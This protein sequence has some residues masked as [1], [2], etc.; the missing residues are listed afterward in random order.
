MPKKRVSMRKIREVLRLT[1][2]L[3]LSVREVSKATGVGKTAVG[4]FVARAKV[5]GITWPVPPEI[6]DAELERRLFTPAE[7]HD[8][9]TR[10]VPD[11]A[12]VHEELKREGV[13]RFTLWEE[14]RAEVADGYGYA[15]FCQLYGEW[16]KR[17]SPTMR[18]THV[19]G[20][21][22]FVDWAGGKVP[23][24]NPVTGEVH[25]ASI[26]VAVLGA[27]SYSYSE[28]R[29]TETLPDWIGAHVNTLDFL[30][31]VMKAAVPD[32]LKAGITKPSRYEPG[33][34]RTYQ[35]LADH[36][37]FVV[38]PTRQQK[39]RDKA[40]VEN[41]VGIV[42]RYLLGRLRNRRFF[43]LAELNDATRECVAAINAKV[44][45]RLNKSRNELFA[46]L[47]RPALKE[48]PTERYSYAEWK[49]CTVAPD[50]H[51]EVELH[52]YSVPFR[53]LR[54]SIDA[55]YTDTT[56]E[57]FHKGER[58]A[59]H[60]RSK[61]PY[62]H[63]T[64]PEHMPSSH[65][66]YAE[67]TPARMLSQAGEIG[68]ATVALFEAIMRAKPH[69]E[70]GFRSCL[71]IISLLRSYGPERIEAAAK[72]GNDIGATSYGSIK[73]ILEKGLDRS[74]APSTAADTRPIQH[75]NIRG[76]GY[77]H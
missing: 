57:L 24:I 66:R 42:S 23:I 69:P 33:I 60:V 1:H 9:P 74:Y 38:L 22:L 53:L 59:S 71:G 75:A 67:W 2:E 32:N 8:V 76:R 55:R 45:K 52:Y 49:R 14:Y 11:W 61:L 19:A 70:Q 15:R 21:K 5:I 16:K 51:V 39:P 27:S 36:Y 73:S 26:F 65:R 44:M 43:S 46:S 18:Q 12:K 10:T 68:P 40:K 54:E 37:G 64:L 13:T 3:G 7:C 58:V 41:G 35:D 34:N 77:Y 30:G 62:K 48:L 29:W 50:Y 6:S 63:T 17:L 28:A 56:V 31:G 20:D 25:E 4:D 47:D 72:R